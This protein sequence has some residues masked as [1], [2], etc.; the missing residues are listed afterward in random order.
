MTAHGKQLGGR[1]DDFTGTTVAYNNAVDTLHQSPVWGTMDLVLRVLKHTRWVW[2]LA[3]LAVV[4]QRWG[5]IRCSAILFMTADTCGRIVTGLC[6]YLGLWPQYTLTT[7]VQPGDIGGEG[8]YIAVEPFRPTPTWDASAAQQVVV[9]SELLAHLQ[10]HAQFT[11]RDVK[12]AQELKQ[13][14]NAWC[15]KTQMTQAET[16]AVIP[17]AVAAAMAMSPAE[18]AAHQY[19]GGKLVNSSIWAANRFVTSGRLVGGQSIPLH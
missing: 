11:S 10:I 12:V 7:M 4:A 9:P 19:L 13:K 8:E 18:R 3:V 5:W 16:A 2:P 17:V 1:V 6:D 15:Q 14:A